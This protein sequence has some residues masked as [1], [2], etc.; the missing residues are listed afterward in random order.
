VPVWPADVFRRPWCWREITRDEACSLWPGKKVIVVSRPIGPAAAAEWFTPGSGFYSSNRPYVFKSLRYYVLIGEAEL[1]VRGPRTPET[2]GG[3]SPSHDEPVPD[4]RPEREGRIEEDEP[5]TLSQNADLV[6][7][8]NVLNS[9]SKNGIP[10]CEE[11]EKA[12]LAREER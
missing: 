7:I 5:D 8:A 12:R 4:E 6:A 9:A 3:D 11:C 10:F 1:H 2:E